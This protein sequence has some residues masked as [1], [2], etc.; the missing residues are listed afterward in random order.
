MKKHHE[1]L[2]ESECKHFFINNK[3]SYETVTSL[4]LRLGRI[5]DHVQATLERLVAINFLVIQDAGKVKIFYLNL[6]NATNHTQ[7]QPDFPIKKKI[8]GMDLL[9]TREKEVLLHVL[10]GLNNAAIAHELFI[11]IHTVKNH[12]TNIFH[13]MEVKDRVQLMKKIYEKK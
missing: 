9:T 3:N 12:V 11:S 2:L 1:Q 10:K 13:K 6:N 8:C 7:V 4:S 5:E